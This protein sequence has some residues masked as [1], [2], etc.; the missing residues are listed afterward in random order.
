MYLDLQRNFWKSDFK[1]NWKMTADFSSNGH[2]IQYLERCFDVLH[3]P[4]EMGCNSVQC[5]RTKFHLR[6]TDL[7]RRSFT[8]R[9]SAVVWTRVSYPHPFW[10]HTYTHVW[11]RKC[12][13]ISIRASVAM[14]LL[15]WFSFFILNG[16]KARRL[17][18]C[19]ILQ[20][21]VRVARPVRSDGRSTKYI[22]AKGLHGH[23]VRANCFTSYSV[24]SNRNRRR[25]KL[26]RCNQAQIISSKLLRGDLNYSC[27][28]SC[29]KETV[30]KKINP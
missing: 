20:I 30:R 4:F 22:T 29:G 19:R 21:D 1:I 27:F 12:I 11:M 5:F 3:E 25:G 28:S 2:C 6:N 16:L 17:V 24:S 26:S 7:R 13:W 8:S 9:S 15:I 10:T 18:F 14:N 23:S